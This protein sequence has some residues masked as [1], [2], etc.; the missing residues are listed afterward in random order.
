V[1]QQLAQQDANE[2]QRR[3]LDREKVLDRLWEIANISPEITRGSITGKVKAIAMIVAMENFI[4]NRPTLSSEKKSAAVPGP[5]LAP[6]PVADPPSAPGPS[7][8]NS[9]NQLI[10]SKAP[11]PYVPLFNPVPD[12][13]I[14][15]PI[16]NPFVRPR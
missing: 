1:Q 16:R 14:P 8:S 13:G 3:N 10:A 5:K 11:K 15:F 12:L 2:Q 6:L 7:Q 9:A 4:P